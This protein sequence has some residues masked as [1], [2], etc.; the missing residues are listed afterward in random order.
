MSL[1][2]LV[3]GGSQLA[4]QDDLN[5]KWQLA[6]GVGPYRVD[7]LAGT[8]IIPTAQLV[9][10]FGTR[11]AAGLSVGWIPNAGFYN[12]TALTVDLGFGV[13]SAPGRVEWIGLVGPSGIIGGDSDGTPYVGVA[14]HAGGYVTAWLSDRIGITGGAIARVWIS[15]GNSRF[16]P[17][18]FAGLR[19]RL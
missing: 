6:I 1:V 15:A 11:G 17:S 5:R 14:G 19:F 8:P 12:L 18:G 3:A 13:R 10:S 2:L 4:A 16:S 9:K 7:D